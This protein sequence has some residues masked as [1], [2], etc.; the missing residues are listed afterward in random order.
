MAN[1]RILVVDDEPLIVRACM[2]MLQDAGF[3]A[4][5]TSDSRG[6]LARLVE[7]PASGSSAEPFDLA[8]VDI[9]MPGVGGLE[10]LRE[11]RREVPDLSVVMITGHGRMETALSALRLGAEGF[12]LKPFTGGELLATVRDVLARRL[13]LREHHRLLDR[14]PL[15]EIGQALVSATDREDLAERAIEV[16]SQEVDADGAAL[17]LR[18]GDQARWEAAAFAGEKPVFIAQGREMAQSLLSQVAEARRPLY[19]D[20]EETGSGPLRLSPE[21]EDGRTLLLPLEVQD[22]TIGILAVSRP[23]GLPPLELSDVLF[24]GLLARQVVTALENARLYT[25]VDRSRQEWEATFAAITDGISVHDATLRVIRANPALARMLETSVPEVV[26]QDGEEVFR[27]WYGDVSSPLIAAAMSVQA[28]TFE[29][30]EPGGRPGRFVVHI[31]PLDDG[32]G[33]ASGVVQVIQDVT[34]EKKVQA[35]LFQTE[36][37]AALGRMVTSLAH[38]I[39]NPLQALDSGLALLLNPSLAQEK[40]QRYLRVASTEVQ[41]LTAIVERMLNFYRPSSDVTTPTDIHE[42]L[43]QVLA[44]AGKELEHQGVK[45]VTGLG[46]DLPTLDLVSD[47]IKQVFLNVILNAAEAMPEGGEVHVSAALTDSEVQV[48]F[49]DTGVGL[50]VDAVSHIFEPFYTLKEG[51]T[52]LGL[53]IS[54]NIVERHGGRIEVSSTPGEGSVFTICLPLEMPLE[55]D[56]SGRTPQ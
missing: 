29:V 28:Q 4:E 17:L 52:G 24:L 39:N 41:R 10:I 7:K 11:T 44:L 20:G 51:G 42:V 40:R 9:L 15:L 54:L 37:L 31:Y 38:E 25:A 53:S 48:M 36:K 46:P 55:I 5:G 3:Q 27:D 47:Q 13:V 22:R 6:A 33:Q 1:E 14:F 26:G 23:V 21:P 56:S 35:R 49:E 16:I 34:E 18:N 19:L 50:P 45:V 43:D 12:I 2:Q 30:S 32:R 8:L